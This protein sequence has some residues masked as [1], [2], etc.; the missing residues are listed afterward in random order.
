MEIKLDKK[1]HICILA[2]L[3]PNFNWPPFLNRLS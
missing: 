1:A 2:I 3:M